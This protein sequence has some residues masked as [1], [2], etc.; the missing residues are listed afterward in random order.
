M[1]EMTLLEAAKLS[2]DSV[3]QA[4]TKIIAETSPMLELIPQKGINGPSY[5]Y[6]M[7]SYLGGVAFRGVNAGYTANNGVINPSTEHLVIVGGEIKIDNFIVDVQSNA[8][9]AKTT[10]YAMKARAF[11]LF[12]SEQFIEGDTAVNPYGFDGIRKRIPST[13]AQY[14]NAAT[15]GATLTLAMLDQ[16]LDTVVGDNSTKFLLMNKTLR[17]KVTELARAQTGTARIEYTQ[18]TLNRQQTSYAGAQIRVIE[19]EDDA[20]TF[21]GFDEDDGS[22]YLD[23]ST[24]YCIRPGMEFIH[25]IMHGSIPTVKDFGEQEAGPYHMGRIEA[26]MG[27]VFKHPRSAARLA[28]INNA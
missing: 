10:Y 16:L 8:I 22:S 7:E 27:I 15:G 12:Y 18:D 26:Y 5:R 21:L 4:I 14:I 23:T 6:N 2:A 25:G 20:S 24:I 11:G 17:R 13:S 1:P 28:H 9:D 3:E 19:R